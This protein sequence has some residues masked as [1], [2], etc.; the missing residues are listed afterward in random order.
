ADVEITNSDTNISRRGSTSE[1]GV[2]YF[3]A[4]PPGPYA[5]VVEVPGF[6]RWSGRLVLQVGETTAIDPVLELGAIS[7]TVDVVGRPPVTSTE[8]VDLA[9]VKDYPRIHQLPLNGRDITTLFDLTPG[10]E[11]AG[12]ARVNGLKVGSMEITL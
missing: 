2:F 1:A 7:I 4:V 5:V 9:N 3:G 10:V 8:T 12:N 11:G 6:K